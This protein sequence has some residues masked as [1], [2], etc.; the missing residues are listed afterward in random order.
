MTVL[1]LEYVIIKTMNPY[2][3]NQSTQWASQV[4]P[5]I[6]W[7]ILGFLLILSIFM[8]AVIFYHY[9]HFSLEPFKSA[10]MS[11]LYIF[12]CGGL[13][14]LAFIGVSLYLNSL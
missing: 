6:L 5:Y 2:Y 9:K 14:L 8:G 3:F 12:V 10:F 1:C 13:V 11:A 4:M 7:P